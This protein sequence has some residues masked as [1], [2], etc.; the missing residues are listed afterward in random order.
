METLIVSIVG[1]SLF[2]LLRLPLPWMLGA[3][4]E[5]FDLGKPAGVSCIGPMRIRNGGL[6]VLGAMMGAWFTAE[7]VRQIV[8]HLPG[9]LLVTGTSLLFGVG[10]A[11]FTMRQTGISLASSLLG[12]TP[13][14]FS[15]MVVLCDEFPDAGPGRCQRVADDS[16]VVG[17]LYCTFFG[18]TRRGRRC[19]G[20]AANHGRRLGRQSSDL[21][22]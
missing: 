6:I 22:K 16:F 9:M 12:S 18:H 15:Q 13:G 2:Y 8:A 14:G 17:S 11:F 20:C 1:G 5:C 10:A 7:T 3:T 19:D 21:I 4:C